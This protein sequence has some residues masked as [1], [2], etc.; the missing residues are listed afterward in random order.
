M[1][2]VTQFLRIV[3]IRTKIVS[4]SGLAIGT[5]YTL[6]RYGSIDPV[7]FGLFAAAVVSVDMATTGFNSFFDYYH[8]ID[9]RSYNREEDKV[10]VYQ[11]VPGGVALLVSLILYTLAAGLGLVLAWLVS[12][13]VIPIGVLSFLVGVAYNTGPIPIS[14]T[15]VG[16]LFAGGFLGWVLVTLTIF[17]LRPDTSIST[18]V[19]SPDMM[20]GVP[21]FLIVASILSV[22][23]ACDRV[24]DRRAGRRTVAVIFDDPVAT[25]LIYLEG[26]AAFGFA[27]FLATTGVLPTITAYGIL[28]ATALAL[29]VYRGMHRRGYTHDTKSLS[30]GSISQ[31]F[32]LFTVGIVVPTVFATLL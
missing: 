14:R 9:R 8:G 32:L 23:N 13:W 24:G 25:I 28:A 15:P 3:E 30:M 12:P 17:V 4:V 21:S 6:Y 16:E 22:N 19:T 29:P 10:L 20:V 11:N 31:V 1:I 5:V 18:F 26:A 7:V 27:L 2:T